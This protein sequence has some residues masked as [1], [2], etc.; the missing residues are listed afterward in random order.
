MTTIH[1]EDLT[2]L[3]S[4]DVDRALWNE[5]RYDPF[6][7][8]LCGTREYQ[9]R[10]IFTA[11]RFLAGGKYAN[12]RALARENHR[13]NEKL[14]AG[15]DSLAEL[16]SRL[17]LPD[18]LSCSLD[19]A[20]GTGKS[21]VLYGLAA[22]LLAEGKVDR[23]LVLCPSNTIERGLLEKFR[24][25]AVDADLREL[26]PEGSLVRAPKV[27]NASETIGPGCV[28]VENYH[29]VLK[30]VKS[31]IRDSLRGGGERVLVLNDE[32]HH[33]ASA[34]RAQS[35]QW[36]KFLLD[37]EFGFRRVVGV[38]GTC[39]VDNDYFA[40][41]VS[42]YSLRQAIEERVVKDV[43]YLVDEP[44]LDERPERWQL[45]YQVHQSKKRELKRRGVRP[46]TIVVTK[47][48]NACQNLAEDLREFLVGEEGIS[49]EQA[50]EK[51]LV[52]TSSP[53]HRADVARLRTVDRPESKAEW[54]LSVA[55][56]NE[57]WDV[58]NVF[59]IVPHEEKA[60]NSKLLI[61]QVLGRGLRIPD[62]WRGPPLVVNVFNHAAWA[63]RIRHLADE[64]LE[65]EN[66]VSSLALPD[67]PYHFEL[68]DLD[69]EKKRAEDEFQMTGEYR[70]F[71]DGYV[72]VASHL[73]EESDRIEFER[74][75]SGGHRAEEVR[76]RHRTHTAEEIAEEMFRLMRGID[77][78][79]QA[80]DDP[81][82]RTNYAGKYGRERLEKIVRESVRRAQIAADEIPEKTRQRLLGGLNVLNRRISKRVTYEMSAQALNLMNT[83]DRQ[84][85]S[86]SATELRRD[87]AI[88]YRAGSVDAL[89]VGQRDFFTDRLADPD[90][91]FAAKALVVDNAH[92]FKTPLN[93]VIADSNPERRFV[94]ALIEPK[95]AAS[96][97][98]WLKN[99]AAGFYAI[100]YAW[101]R[102]P[103]R[104]R[105][106]SHTKRG[107][108]SPD[109][110]IKQGDLV[111][112]VEIKG[113][114]E[115]AEPSPENIAKHRFAAEH[116]KRLN[117]WLERAGESV[118]YHFTMLTPQDF[119]AFFKRLESRT[120]S[121]FS[122]DL[123]VKARDMLNGNGNGN[124]NGR[125]R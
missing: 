11:L 59:Q 48:I 40:D 5:A 63:G 46:L 24:M 13:D 7:D 85:D 49:P 37:K 52:V 29:A 66:R 112:V 2:L 109:F 14:R 123:D 10:A 44:E 119:P 106:T 22:I 94:R 105:R 86:C 88:F 78:E 60:F 27:V 100:E 19:L 20:T 56:L 90:G 101:G 54:I 71:R 12:L 124:G 50:K 96:V 38:S 69:Y 83:G 45:I 35:G 102:S 125:A 98:G 51:T 80:E 79:N 91:E 108:F 9:K 61:S 120:L 41:V 70:I 81:A 43:D 95:S 53:D 39:Y 92:D 76:I 1:N 30:H 72:D 121:G 93:L 97:D 18:L 58:K 32:A 114:E 68:H 16:E 33:I 117:Q 118:R 104:V 107:M 26:M 115:L 111:C 8:A 75:G 84:A 3:V 89:P 73:A 34:S 103:E 64:V 23:V 122:S 110:F 65:R 15:Y 87:K 42:R 36:K 99:T 47:N 77:Q 74:I 28:C 57:G 55:M 31:S 82:R 62:D 25:L 116:F 17:T 6:V 67:S 4:K 113:K 21:F